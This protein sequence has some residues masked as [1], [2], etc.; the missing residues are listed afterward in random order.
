MIPADASVSK[1]SYR[2]QLDRGFRALRFEPALESEYRASTLDTGLSQLRVMLTIGLLF[3]FA[4]PLLDYIV[5]GPGFGGPSILF[6]AALTQ[7]LI[8]MMIL[9][10]VYPRLRSYLTGLGILVALSIGLPALFTPSIATSI[11]PGTSLTGYAVLVFYIYLFLG[12]RFRPAVLTAVSISVCY[13]AA[14]L[15]RGAPA[16]GMGYSTL[17]LIFSNLIGASG[18]Y[19]LEYTRRMSFLEERQLRHIATRDALTG[20][21]N[22]KFINEHL[23]MVWRHCWREQLPLS[24]VLLDIDHFKA[25]NDNFGHQAGDDCLIEIARVLD[26][27]GRRPMDLAGRFGGEEFILILPDCG[28]DDAVQLVERFR[29]DIESLDIDHPRSSTGDKVTVSAG[30]AQIFPGQSK[31]S[32]QGLIQLADEAL[33]HAKNTGR[34][35]IHTVEAKRAEAMETG[36]FELTA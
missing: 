4:I 25:Y 26:E 21:A 12:L 32:S 6:R 3:G 5:D 7:P 30:I 10:S 13:L 16:A 31:R 22:R 18:L 36:I 1:S 9:A 15:I 28:L 17:W 14:A 34:N 24:L 33:Y 27:S 8:V 11:G 2:K 23:T 35:R 29:K 19:N 20:I